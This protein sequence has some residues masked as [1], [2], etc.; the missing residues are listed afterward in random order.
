MSTLSADLKDK[1]KKDSGNV[2]GAE[3]LGLAIAQKSKEKGI[4]RVVFDRAGYLYHGRVKAL[5]LAAR[6]GGL[7]F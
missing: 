7:S 6:K 2:K 1:I 4:T 3:I 5:A